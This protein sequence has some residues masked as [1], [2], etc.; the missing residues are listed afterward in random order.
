MTD[1]GFGL[2]DRR[3]VIIIV[4]TMVLAQALFNLQM[5]VDTTK[6]DAAFIDLVILTGY[7]YLARSIYRFPVALILSP[8]MVHQ[9]NWSGFGFLLDD[10]LA[11][12]QL[13]RD[14]TDNRSFVKA[15]LRIAAWPVILIGNAIIALTRLVVI[16]FSF[17]MWASDYSRIYA[18]SRTIAEGFAILDRIGLVVIALL[19]TVSGT[20]PLVRALGI[21]GLIMIVIIFTL[22]GDFT[23]LVKDSIK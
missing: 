17:G 18:R 22:R 1:I 19:T 11:M 14:K 16:V 6:L 20:Q 3:T 10:S 15:L 23:A 5:P 12:P 4:F 13:F 9:V 7:F 8:R 2:I 21:A